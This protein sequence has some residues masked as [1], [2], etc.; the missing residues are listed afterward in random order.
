[1]KF[2][3]ACSYFLNLFTGVVYFAFPQVT[4]HPVYI[5]ICICVNYIE[6]PIDLWYIWVF[7]I[8]LLIVLV[9]CLVDCCLQ[10]W[11]KRRRRPSRK[12]VTVVTLSSLD[13]LLG[14]ETSEHSNFQ[15]WTSNETS[16]APFCAVNLGGLE[17]G[18][19][20]SYEELFS[21]NK[22]QLAL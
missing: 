7:L 19:P 13:S 8:L 12:M 4:L 2:K 14:K 17:S 22:A 21:T 10:C 1:M 6:Q 3:T 11:M 9:R 5:Y 15:T 20:P 18:A 16:G